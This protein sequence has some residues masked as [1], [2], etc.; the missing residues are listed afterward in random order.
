MFKHILVATDGSQCS[1]SATAQAITLAKELGACITAFYAKLPYG[2]PYY[3]DY[4][5][6]ELPTH[7]KYEELAESEAQDILGAVEKRCIEANVICTKL[8]ATS[9]VIYQ[10]IINAANQNKCDLICMA[11][12]G[13]RGVSAL[14]LGSE[15]NKVLTHSKIPVLVFR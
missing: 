4:L 11:S 2:V 7:S 3:G 6:Y 9:N 5:P 10:A 8:T 1:I 13:R 14:I 12:H 15:T